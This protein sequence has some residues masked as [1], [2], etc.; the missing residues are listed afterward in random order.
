MRHT[1]V[2]TR[3]PLRVDPT[4]VWKECLQ[5]SMGSGNSSVNLPPQGY[6][7]GVFIGT[8]VPIALKQERLCP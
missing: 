8:R 2:G 6:C 4:G 3:L 1:R 5:G 7:T